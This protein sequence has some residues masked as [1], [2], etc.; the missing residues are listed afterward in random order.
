MTL[1]LAVRQLVREMQLLPRRIGNEMSNNVASLN[2]SLRSF[3]NPMNRVSE[4]FRKAEET[5]KK[6]VSMGTTVAKFQRENSDALRKLTGG[7]NDLIQ[8]LMDF[9]QAGLRKT[10]DE[11]NKLA[12]RMKYSGQSTGAL[13]DQM[14]K[15]SLYT[16]GN[17]QVLDSFAKQNMELAKTYQVTNDSLIQALQS[18]DSTLRE[19]AV[20]SGSSRIGKAVAQLVAQSP[21]AKAEII[22]AARQLADPT[23]QGMRL[24]ALTQNTDLILKINKAAT[25]QESAKILAE[26]I[27]KVSRTGRE[28]TGGLGEDEAG[29][30]GKASILGSAFGGLEAFSNFQ[31]AQQSIDESLKNLV[32][33][34]VSDKELTT[35]EQQVA[36]SKRFYEESLNTFYPQSLKYL[37]QL[38][39][40]AL[41]FGGPSMA[42]FLRRSLLNLAGTGATMLGHSAGAGMRLAGRSLLARGLGVLGGPIGILAGLAVQ[43]GP[44][45][46]DYFTSNK[47]D[48]DSKNIAQTAKKTTELAD[49]NKDAL[50]PNSVESWLADQVRRS[51]TQNQLQVEQSQNMKQLIS[52]VEQLTSVTQKGS[53][54]MTRAVKNSNGE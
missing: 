21:Q 16:N 53:K 44:D 1:A 22:S 50:S 42:M 47:R 9:R 33:S 18:L 26:G 34:D 8:V 51:Y 17:T 14:T 7:Q 6:A 38:S 49:R 30:Y 32:K 15:L 12:V 46:Y 43:F 40:A 54:D 39:T 45:I 20:L 52:A 5:Q 24:R 41:V 28:F 31:F 25:D 4:A 37:K 23:A 11:L 35:A 48:D 3:I 19:Q 10:G 36:D 27:A 13:V 2:Q 29:Q